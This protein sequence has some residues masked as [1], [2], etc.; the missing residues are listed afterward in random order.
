MSGEWV[1]TKH[2]RAVHGCQFMNS[3]TPM[4]VATSPPDPKN[5]VR[6]NVEA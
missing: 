3:V 2:E 5:R 6:D 4:Q 1:D